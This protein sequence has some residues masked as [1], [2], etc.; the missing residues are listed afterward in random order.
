MQSVKRGV[1]GALLLVVTA[2]C[3]TN[4]AATEKCKGSQDSEVCNACCREHGG[5]GHVFSSGACSCLK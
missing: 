2:A 3:S 4:E 5:N 1:V